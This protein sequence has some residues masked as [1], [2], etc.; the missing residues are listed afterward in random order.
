MRNWILPAFALLAACSASPPPAAP[1]EHP[2]APS[3]TALPTTTSQATTA[4]TPRAADAPTAAPAFVDKVWRVGASSTLQPG[5][6]YAFLGDGT[7]VIDAPGGTPMTGSWRQVDGRLTMVE[8]GIAYPTDIVAIDA[9]HL[10]LRSHNP[11]GS[12][13]IPLDVAPDVPLPRTSAK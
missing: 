1:V 4:S 11:G 5:T 7:L 3:T 10:V 8:D 6:T 13:L 12:V 9:S 2:A